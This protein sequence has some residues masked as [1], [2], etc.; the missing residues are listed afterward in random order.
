MYPTIGRIV[1]Y[2]YPEFAGATAIRPAIVV[3]DWG[4][5]CVNLRVFEDG[6]NDDEL[7]AVHGTWPTSVTAADAIDGG[8]PG[9]VSQ[10]GRWH[11]P[12][13]S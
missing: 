7:T 6:G 11:W 10:V 9:A 2:T 8:A 4:N 3:R 13:R 12:A 1:H 5:G